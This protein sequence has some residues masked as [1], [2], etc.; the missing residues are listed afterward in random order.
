MTYEQDY[1]LYCDIAQTFFF[2]K[3]NP[4]KKRLLLNRLAERLNIETIDK[5]A[6]VKR[7]YT[8]R[9]LRNDY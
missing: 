9:D 1:E 3:M 5:Y 6:F 8:K 7:K 4:D 2:V